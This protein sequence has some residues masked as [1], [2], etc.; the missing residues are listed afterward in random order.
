MTVQV[1]QLVF[2]HCE[3]AALFMIV[4]MFIATGVV[5]ILQTVLQELRKQNISVY[6]RIFSL[7][8][9][10]KRTFIFFPNELCKFTAA[11]REKDE[12]PND[13]NDRLIR[14]ATSYFS[15]AICRSSSDM[16]VDVDSNDEKGASVL[17]LSNDFLQRVGL[18]QQYILCLS[19][20][21]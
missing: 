18:I 21:Y 9:N 19:L 17:L 4:F 5:V 1:G 2:V 15:D 3:K 13:Y 7:L 8:Q 20:N 11:D 10:E 12:T 16:E 6:K 14:I